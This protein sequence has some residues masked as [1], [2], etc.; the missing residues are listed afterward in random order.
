[1]LR[2]ANA[3]S[4]IGVLDGASPS[5]PSLASNALTDGDSV[6]RRAVALCA[7][8]SWLAFS[9]SASLLCSAAQLSASLQLAVVYG[10]DDAVD[11]SVQCGE[12]AVEV[13]RASAQ[14]CVAWAIWPAR[15]RVGPSVCS[16][17]GPYCPLTLWDML[18]GSNQATEIA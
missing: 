3:F 16:F 18:S 12:L 13:A 11:L 14:D 17:P 9:S 8:S 10:G 5:T 4:T 15:D 2:P 6:L 1:M 7:F